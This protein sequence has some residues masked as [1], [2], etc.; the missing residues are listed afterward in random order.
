M[1]GKPS[2]NTRVQKLI[3]AV[4]LHPALKIASTCDPPIAGPPFPA[5][6]EA[7]PKSKPLDVPGFPVPTGCQ[8]ECNRVQERSLY[9]SSCFGI[10]DTVSF[11]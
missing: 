8:I 10:F 9:H 11:I 3:P 5:A 2:E 1:G 7:G 6:I 4:E